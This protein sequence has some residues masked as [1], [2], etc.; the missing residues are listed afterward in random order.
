MELN[1]DRWSRSRALVTRRQ[2]DQIGRFL[3]VHGKCFITKV[4]QIYCDFWAI[5]KTSLFMQK[6]HWKHFGQLLE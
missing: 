6:L 4:A 5:L 1:S 2:C 3:K